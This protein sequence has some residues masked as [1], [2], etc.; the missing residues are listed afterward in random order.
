MSCGYG[1]LLGG[2]IVEGGDEE[3]EEVRIELLVA[4]WRAVGVTEVLADMRGVE[5]LILSKLLG[6]GD[7]GVRTAGSLGVDLDVAALGIGHGVGVLLENG[8]E[9]EL[10]EGVT[11]VLGVLDIRAATA[12]DNMRA[13]FLAFLR[14][15]EGSTEGIV[16]FGAGVKEEMTIRRHDNRAEISVDDSGNNKFYEGMYIHVLM[17]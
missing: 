4:A 5:L 9:I 8:Q 13:V 15:L 2:E 11:L 7:D 17:L 6:I 1:E 10:V 12:E 16:N 14:S 3:A